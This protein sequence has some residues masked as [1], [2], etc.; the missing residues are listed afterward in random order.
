MIN[1]IQDIITTSPVLAVFVVFWAG[2]MASLSSCTLIRLPIVFGY[3]SGADHSKRKSVLLSVCLVFGMVVSYVLLGMAL[4]FFKNLSLRLVHI[5]QYAYTTLGVFLLGVG[6]FYAGLIKIGRPHQV[7]CPVP[8]RSRQ[9][10]SYIG[11][12]VFGAMFAFLEMPSCPCCASL[13]FV[14]AGVATL[15]ASPA[16]SFFIFLSFVLG[17]SMPVLLVGSSSDLF[18]RLSSKVAKGEKYVQFGA[19]AVLMMMGLYFL[20]IA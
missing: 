16:Y 9:Q 13:L 11:A 10:G 20:I 1:S 18:K 14:I 2:V 15:A 6:I 12:F 7:N 17:Q 5:S 8:Y 4:I 3:V 19:G